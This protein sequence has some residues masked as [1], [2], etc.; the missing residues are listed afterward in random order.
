MN[1][2]EKSDIARWNAEKWRPVNYVMI[3]TV[4]FIGSSVPVALVAALVADQDVH[5]NALAAVLVAADAAVE[6]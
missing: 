1:Q 6:A 5:A 4:H 2:E 3:P